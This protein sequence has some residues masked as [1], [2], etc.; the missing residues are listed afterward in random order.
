MSE[1]E[2]SILVLWANFSLFFHHLTNLLQFTNYM[3]ISHTKI[4]K[5][6][7]FFNSL[8]WGIF[9]GWQKSEKNNCKAIF[10]SH[11]DHVFLL[12]FMVLSFMLKSAMLMYVERMTFVIDGIYGNFLM[13]IMFPFITLNMFVCPSRSTLENDFF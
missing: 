8:I 6:A 4:G 1:K 11:R 2:K 10:R 12:D 5:Y 9:I 13:R 3:L 7:D